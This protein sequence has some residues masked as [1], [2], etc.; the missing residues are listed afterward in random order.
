MESASNNRIETIIRD[1]YGD[2]IKSER[3]G[4]VE[5]N[6]FYRFAGQDGI[7]TGTGYSDYFIGGAGFA[8]PYFGLDQDPANV[9]FNLYIYGTGDPNCKLVTNFNEDDNGNKIADTGNMSENYVLYEDEYAWEVPVN[10]KG[11]RLV[12]VKYSDLKLSADGMKA[13]R[14][15]K[16]Q[17]P[18]RIAKINFVLISMAK[19][20]RTSVI[21]DFA[22]FT[23]GKPFQPNEP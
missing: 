21:F 9:F 14:G 1:M 2:T 7:Y 5:G 22:T 23:M 12:S 6:S 20:G 13:V 16:K 17:E 15:N 8:K 10:W 19:G 4:S 3:K 11:W 18:H